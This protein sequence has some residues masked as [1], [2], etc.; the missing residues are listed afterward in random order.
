MRN[1]EC[2]YTVVEENCKL[3]DKEYTGYGI[4]VK[5]F[6][7]GCVRVFRDISRQREEVAKLCKKC[8]DLEL[9]PIHI[10]DVICDFI[11]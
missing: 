10:E 1:F 9:D 8:N 6:A 7:G 4:S 11:G 3:C 5:D 2:I